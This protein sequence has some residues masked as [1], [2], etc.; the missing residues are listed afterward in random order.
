VT[1]ATVGLIAGTNTIAVEM[2][3]DS[4][5]GT[6]L[7]FDLALIGLHGTNTTDGI[8]L[9]AP[10][11][12]TH[13]NMPATVALSSYAA[14]SGGAV[15]L[16]EYYDGAAK[17]GEGSVAPYSTMWSGA[18]AG[19]HTL[20]AV[21]TYGAGL[22]M[23]SPPSAIA[24]GPVPP[25]IAPVF[26]QF[27]SY[28]AAWNY[29]DSAGAVSN[30]WAGLGFD[31]SAWPSGNARFG[32][33][34]DGEST[35]LTPGR[36]THYFR[37]SIV[38][39]NG[40]ALD[41]L[42]FFVVRDDGVV[43]YLNGRE[44]FRT[45]MPSGAVTATTLASV[46]IETPDETIPVVY[47]LST[48][49]AGLLSGTNVVAVELHQSSAN[50]S[51]ASFDMLLNGAGTTE[52]RIYLAT[53]AN[54]SSLDFGNSIDVEAQASSDRTLTAVEF[55]SDGTNQFG[56][57]GAPPYRVTWSGAPVGPHLITARALD[58]LGGSLI[59]EPLSVSLRYPAVSLVRVVAQAGGQL[60][61][62]W[63]TNATGYHLYS[64]P[65]LTTNAAS[66]QPWG[67]SPSVS[68]GFNIL[69]IPPTNTAAFYRLQKP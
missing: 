22:R 60:R 52:R 33:G 6:D 67:G 12:G 28:G 39:T 61:I 35:A 17:V 69:T 63:P 56:T 65:Q 9:T 31:D 62:A 21:A 43:V 19:T 2:H 54:Y 37:K 48:S 30:G 36:I 58:S 59:S 23:T 68:N 32:W 7:G 15:T 47:S 45:N 4:I 25:T 29:W 40:G 8:Y 5:T 16:V 1:L 38:V 13:Y 46:T 3:Q 44:I 14:S 20:T 50:S 55:F 51:D 26:T 34:I 49:A 41:S 53:P 10:A 57:A 27:F 11:N 66:W 42:T 24:I 64:S 18:A